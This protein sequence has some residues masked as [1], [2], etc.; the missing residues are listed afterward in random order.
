MTDDPI[1][2]WLT[3]RGIACNPEAKLRQYDY[4]TSVSVDHRAAV[5]VTC[6]ECMEHLHRWHDEQAR[7]ERSLGAPDRSLRSRPIEDPGAQVVA[8]RAQLAEAREVLAA[9]VAAHPRSSA[10]SVHLGR[11]EAIL[12]EPRG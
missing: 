8:L 10:M 1:R 5:R 9:H 11:L 12:R 3:P 6:P 4:T 7:Q 2:H